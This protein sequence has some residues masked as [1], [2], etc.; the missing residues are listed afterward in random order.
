MP[1]DAVSHTDDHTPAPRPR[2]RVSRDIRVGQAGV[3]SVAVAPRAGDTLID[4]LVGARDANLQDGG[5]AESTNLSPFVKATAGPPP[6]SSSNPRT[7]ADLVAMTVRRDS[8]NRILVSLTDRDAPFQPR[9]IFYVGQVP[10][11]GRRRIHRD[12]LVGRELCLFSLRF[13]VF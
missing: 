5:T 11:C 12:R 9:Q 1:I 10:H 4:E 3:Q 2:L 13:G 7:P 8:P 6:L